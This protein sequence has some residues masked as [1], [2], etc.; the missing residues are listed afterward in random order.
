MATKQDL[1]V[2]LE[3]L[4]RAELSLKEEKKEAMLEFKRE[5]DSINAERKSILDALEAI[6]HGVQGLPFDEE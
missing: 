4:D 5:F 6:E 1:H 3:V 2:K